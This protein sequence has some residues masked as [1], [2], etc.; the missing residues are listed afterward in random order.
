M[1][2]FLNAPKIRMTIRRLFWGCIVAG[3]SAFLTQALLDEVRTEPDSIAEITRTRLVWPTHFPP[4]TAAPQV[5]GQD[6]VHQRPGTSA[7]R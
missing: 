6:I 7:S 3:A 2:D 1:Q 4:A 5:A